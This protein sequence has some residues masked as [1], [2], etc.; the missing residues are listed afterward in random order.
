MC[1]HFK[2][3]RSSGSAVPEQ[4]TDTVSRQGH[5][6]SRRRPSLSAYHWA[7]TGLSTVST[8]DSRV[9]TPWRDEGSGQ[10]FPRVDDRTRKHSDIKVILRSQ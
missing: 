10:L 7:T 2:R 6:Q 3:Q 9:A 4:P 8:L 1:S 5:S